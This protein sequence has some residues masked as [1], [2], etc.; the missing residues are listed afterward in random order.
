MMATII[1]YRSY[2]NIDIQFEDGAIVKNKSYYAF[3][4]GYV[5]YV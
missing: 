2:Q 5:K 4:C 3:E 1:A